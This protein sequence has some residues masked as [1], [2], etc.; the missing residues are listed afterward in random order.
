M[1]R[2]GPGAVGLITLPQRAVIPFFN[3]PNMILPKKIAAEKAVEY[4][5]DGMT[6]GLGTGSTAT[7]AIQALARKIKQGY[8][9]AALASSITSEKLALQLGIT[10]LGQNE[11]TELDLTIDGAD[12]VDLHHNLIKGGGGALVREKI[13]AYNSKQFIVIVD[14]TKQ[15][16]ELGKFPLPVEIVPFGAQF[17]LYQLK[18]LG[19]EPKVRLQEGKNF[20]SD[21]GNWIID[22]NFGRIPDPP[23]LEKKIQ[24]IPGVVACG[25]FLHQKVHTVITGFADGT[26]DVHS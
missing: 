12:E 10:I 17:T 6:I 7:F 16:K 8:H 22:C 15:V 4:I 24:F 13:L 14:E 19:C 26:V 5:K 2:G 20:I 18:N 23:L 3:Y 1:F 9:I 25:L 21:N 11:V